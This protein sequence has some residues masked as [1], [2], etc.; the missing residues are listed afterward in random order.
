MAPPVPDNPAE[1]LA[2]QLHQVDLGGMRTAD[3]SRLVAV[4]NG[5]TGGQ[6]PGGGPQQPSGANLLEAYKAWRARQTPVDAQ[7]HAGT[8]DD[9]RGD[10]AAIGRRLDGIAAKQARPTGA[11]VELARQKAAK[12][13]AK[14][15]RKARR[16]AA[17]ATPAAIEEHATAKSTRAMSKAISGGSTTV[18]ALTA[19]FAAYRDGGGRLTETAWRNRIARGA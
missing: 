5:L 12:G 17:L 1:R 11:D 14:Q 6:V 19:G 15:L 2:S 16:A 4:G 9:L 7:A 13:A 18:G 8:I 10:V 3:L